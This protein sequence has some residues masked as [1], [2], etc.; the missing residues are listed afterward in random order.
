MEQYLKDDKKVVPV[1]IDPRSMKSHYSWCVCSD[2]TYG[3]FSI[4]LARWKRRVPTRP[5]FSGA[6][7]EMSPSL[8]SA[9]KCM[10]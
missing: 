4:L 8:Q 5:F 10:T 1:V 9:S 3:P 2:E 7:S 6:R